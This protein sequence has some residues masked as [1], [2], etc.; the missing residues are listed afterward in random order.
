ML[1]DSVNMEHMKN[2]IVDKATRI[3]TSLFTIKSY[4]SFFFPLTIVGAQKITKKIQKMPQFKPFFAKSLVITRTGI[5]P[6]LILSTRPLV[7]VSRVSEMA[8]E[9]KKLPSLELRHYKND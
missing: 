8:K 7:F 3:I 1:T 9:R 2:A 4:K 6:A 5:F